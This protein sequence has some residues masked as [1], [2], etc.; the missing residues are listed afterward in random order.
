MN[1]QVRREVAVLRQVPAKP[2]QPTDPY[3]DA[4]TVK[5]VVRLMDQAGKGFETAPA[6]YGKLGEED[7][8]TIILGYLNAVFDT[9][10]ATGETFSVRGKTDTYLNVQNR[11]VLIAECKRWSGAEKYAETIDQLFGYTAWRHAQAVMITFSYNKGLM[12][13]VREADAAIQQHRSYRGEFV[14]K[15]PTYRVS[16]HEHPSD[17]DKRL[18]VHHLLFN[19]YAGQSQ[20]V[21]R[22]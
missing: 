15:H 20:S 1:V 3:L 7:L 16:T 22:R 5:Q 11:A 9:F 19:L 13:V 8:R 2:T 12:R 18:Q 17:C 14:E 4:E 10:A 21:T 6:V